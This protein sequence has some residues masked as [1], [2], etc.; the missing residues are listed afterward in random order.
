MYLRSLA[1]NRLKRISVEPP[2]SPWCQRPR[3]TSYSAAGIER[4]AIAKPASTRRPPEL[5]LRREQG[6]E[7]LALLKDSNPHHQKHLLER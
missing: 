1:R 3:R 2:S 6:T 4:M 5:A 7:T